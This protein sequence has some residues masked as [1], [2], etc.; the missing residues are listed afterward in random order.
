[1]WRSSDVR[2]GTALLLVSGGLF[3]R[4]FY[5]PPPTWD[6]LGMAF[7]PRILLLG[8]MVVSIALMVRSLK[9]PQETE[10]LNWRAFAS[11]AMAMGYVF[12]L[13]YLGFLVGTP[14]F[15]FIA[16][17]LLSDSV[18]F[19]ALA[20]ALLLSAVL[21]TLV[22]LIFQKALLVSLPQGIFE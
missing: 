12:S 9:S 3:W 4:T 15:I 16:V 7:W 1:M 18:R 13:E 10:P 11:L 2:I 5:F 19:S 22:Y 8:L 21:T 14:V 17:V 6:A 20:K